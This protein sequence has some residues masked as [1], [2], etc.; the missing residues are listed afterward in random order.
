DSSTGG[1]LRPA[2]G[3]QVSATGPV[4]AG[5]FTSG[6]QSI[7][8][9]YYVLTPRDILGSRYVVPV[10][11]SVEH[12]GGRTELSRLYIYSFAN[13]NI[14]IRDKLG[15]QTIA[16]TGGVAYDSYALPIG[17]GAEVWND[18]V[19]DP[20]FDFWIL[21]AF[22]SGGPRD[23]WGYQPVDSSLLNK[24]YFMPYSPSNYDPSNNA[25]CPETQPMWVSPVE[26]TTTVNFD[27]D[28]DGAADRTEFLNTL[29]VVKVTDLTDQDNAGT[30]VWSDKQFALAYGID[31][32]CSSPSAGNLD[33]GY[34]ALPFLG[35]W[36]SEFLKVTKSGN[37]SSLQQ[38]SGLVKYTITVAAP[39][40]DVFSVNLTDTLP[41]GWQY[42][43]FST[44]INFSFGG[45]NRSGAAAE[46][47][48]VGQQLLWNGVGNVLKGATLTIVFIARVSAGAQYGANENVAQAEGVDLAGNVFTSEGKFTTTIEPPPLRNKE[49]YL[50]ETSLPV[51]A[52]DGTTTTSILN[53]T[54]P[55]AP[56][57]RAYPLFS[58]ISFY[59]YPE[60]AAELGIYGTV[61]LTAKMQGGATTSTV[62]FDL[63]DLSP[64]G[65]RTQ[66]AR[67]AKT[68]A[69]SITQTYEFGVTNAFY[70]VPVGHA[71]LLQV[72]NVQGTAPTLLYD[73]SSSPAHLD[74]LTYTYVDVENAATYKGASPS[75]Y[76]YR[77]DTVTVRANVTDPFGS[78]DISGSRLT[79]INSLGGTVV[80]DAP[81][82]LDA[83]DPFW[84]SLWKRF[85]SSYDIRT[86]DP[87]GWWTARVTGVEGNGVT[88]VVD[89]PFY[90]SFYGVSVEPDRT[91]VAS[92]GADAQFDE[93][94]R[95]EGVVFDTFD[96]SVSPSTMGWA[97]R[98]YF[99]ARLV[100]RDDDG[101]GG[102]D[103]V[104]FLSDS[105]ANGL[106]D[107]ALGV[108]A[109]AP[110]TV[111]KPVP[112]SAN[113]LD[114]DEMRLFARSIGD[115]LV[116]DS[117][118]LTTRVPGPAERI[119][120]L[121]LHGTSA[122]DRTLD[123]ILPTGAGYTD[124]IREGEIRT[125]RLVPLLGG[126]F[127]VRLAKLVAQLDVEGGASHVVRVRLLDGGAPVAT[128]DTIVPDIRGWYD[129]PVNPSSTY[130]FPAGAQIRIEVSFPD[131]GDPT[132]E[133]VHL[134]YDSTAYP[135][136]V[137][138]TTTT[139]VDVDWVNTYDVSG[140]QKSLFQA[141]DTVL[142][143]ALVT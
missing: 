104:D 139:Y 100:A 48:V 137:E 18:Y 53:R 16:L 140:T 24:E 101:D 83:T 121:Y 108:G 50:R 6:G 78:Y 55:S 131:D 35:N 62:Q 49:L 20:N 31:G 73:S 61:N 96:V 34:S 80:A 110:V 132:Q 136:R 86:S 12:Q 11:S 97:S 3:T 28:G 123:R 112:L 128:Q 13:Q 51:K 59:L 54:V 116:I 84:P 90:V 127:S 1:L 79:I 57:D 89:V 117:A 102:F 4:Q 71:L 22:D 26:D 82:N 30:R 64:S 42:V 17:S 5:L 27:F 81:M 46:P 65:A 94:V 60:L 40:V 68:V 39:R 142:I 67:A 47:I 38:K 21:G 72:S 2:P 56:A 113:Q 37:V 43:P 69:A 70:T 106:P 114:V 8:T 143:R 36:S 103:Y 111:L 52:V 93:T 122:G 87:L 118:L 23:D 138:A 95:N 119:K 85:S 135:S 134:W 88:D 25:A 76:F 33:F 124:Q 125:W 19:N 98:V 120:E 9:R 14:H 105:N 109:S 99:G 41:Q 92:P 29:D 74:I 115:P 15:T 10:G 45:V 129:L 63:F 91:I 75:Q 77:G 44:T 133:R 58:P 141:G 66:I 32:A 7:D 107:I 126:P 130:I